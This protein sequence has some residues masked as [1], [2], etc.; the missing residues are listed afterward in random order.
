VDLAATPPAYPATQQPL[1]QPVN[2]NNHGLLSFLNLRYR[3][4]FQPQL[5]SDKSFYEHLGRFASL[6]FGEQHRRIER[7]EVPLQVPVK[8][9]LSG[10]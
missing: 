4:G 8:R 6:C 10:I 3:M 9:H 1:T 2:V 5:F 7:I